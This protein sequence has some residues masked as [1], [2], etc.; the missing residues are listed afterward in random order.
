[1]AIADVVGRECQPG[2]VR[3]RYAIGNRVLDQRQ[4]ARTAQD[5][6]ARIGAVS[7]LDA[8]GGLGGQHHETAHAGRR[9]RGLVPAGFL[10]TDRRQ[11]PPVDAGFRARFLE[12][13]LVQRQPLAHGADKGG[14][15]DPLEAAERALVARE[16]FGETA[17]RLEFGEVTLDQW[18]EVGAARRQG[19]GNGFGFSQLE[20][21]AQFRMKAASE[22]ELG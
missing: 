15:I 3:F 7:D 21:R 1:M 13:G 12:P 10:V 6:A 19:P 11:Q 17:D 5:T 16:D 18:Q 9:Y 20:C 8:L 14:G 2:S 4:V 22:R